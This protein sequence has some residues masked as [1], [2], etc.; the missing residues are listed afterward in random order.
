MGSRLWA[1]PPKHRWQ[2]ASLKAP[3]GTCK[4]LLCSQGTYSSA[5]QVPTADPEPPCF[6]SVAYVSCFWTSF[7][8]CSS[9]FDCFVWEWSWKQLNSITWVCLLG[10]SPHIKVKRQISISRVRVSVLKSFYLFIYFFL[11]EGSS[12]LGY[13]IIV[14]SD[15]MAKTAEFSKELK[16]IP[17]FFEV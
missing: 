6:P 4:H 5:S 9:I 2:G 12:L 7:E 17:S 16:I 8:Y 13:Q 15:Q 14:R 10:H 3:A 1:L 11:K